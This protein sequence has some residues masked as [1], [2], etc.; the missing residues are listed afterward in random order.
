MIISPDSGVAGN[1]EKF[2]RLGRH[3]TLVEAVSYSV[4]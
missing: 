2:Y 1:G 4:I 3:L